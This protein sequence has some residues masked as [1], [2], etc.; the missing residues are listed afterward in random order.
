M[1]TLLCFPNEVLIAITANIDEIQDLAALVLVNRR[2]C[3]IA[4]TALYAAAASN[5][6]TARQALFYSA[7]HGFIE[8]VRLLLAHGVTLHVA[9]ER[10]DD[11]LA[12]LLLESGAIVDPLLA[13]TER[14]AVLGILDGIFVS[15]V[16]PTCQESPLH[17]AIAGGHYSTAKL[18]LDC[19][20]STVVSFGGIKALHVA[21]WHGALDICRLLV[22][23][24]AS[25]VHE[26]TKA[27]LTPFHFAAAAGNVETVGRFLRDK[28]ADIHASF[29]GFV[30]AGNVHREWTCNAFTH[31]LRTRRYSDALMLLDMDPGFAVPRE[32]QLHPVEACFAPRDIVPGDEEQMT[33][34]LKRL[35]LS[36]DRIPPTVSI[37]ILHFV[38]EKQLSRAINVLLEA[39]QYSV[40]SAVY[41]DVSLSKALEHAQSITGVDAAMAL[42][43]YRVSQ[44]G[45]ATPDVSSVFVRGFGCNAGR[46]NHVPDPAD[47]QFTTPGAVEAKL[48]IAKRFHQRL[49]ESPQCVDDQDLRIAL[50]AACQPGG[51]K[52]C[53]WLA[54][55]GALRLL[56]E[57]DFC[58]MLSRTA[59]PPDLGGSDLALAEWVLEQA[60]REGCKCWVLENCD[61][62]RMIIRAEDCTIPRLLVSQGASLNPPDSSKTLPDDWLFPYCTRSRQQNQEYVFTKADNAL[63]TV[64]ANP[65]MTGAAEF[66]RLAS[67]V[68]GEDLGTLVNCAFSTRESSSR[69]LTLATFVCSTELTELN[70]DTSPSEPT[71]LAM[72]KILLGAGA[73]VRAFV[74]CGGK[75]METETWDEAGVAPPE[76]LYRALSRNSVRASESQDDASSNLTHDSQ[77]AVFLWDDDPMRTAIGSRMPTLVQA[78]L[79]AR[80]PPGRNHPGALQYL[81]AACGGMALDSSMTFGR[82]CPRVLE[83]VLSMANLEDANVPVDVRGRTALSVLLDFF[84]TDDYPAPVSEAIRESVLDHECR[85]EPD[86]VAFESNHLSEMVGLL[87]ARGAKWTT[88]AMGTE[89]SALDGLRVLLR[90]SMRFKSMYKRHNLAEF[91]RH[92]ILDIFSTASF[93]PPPDFNPFEMGTIKATDGTYSSIV[94]E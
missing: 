60:D 15:P 33:P 41:L 37:F 24:D 52:V 59:R 78:M 85:C 86:L 28:G 49:A 64:C 44:L 4:Q 19:G 70:G 61:V 81:R 87:L 16:V 69:I 79:E 51:L 32:N 10:G 54:S 34:I 38:S 14:P 36:S 25:L 55:V 26:R 11:K 75:D 63:V 18:L 68:A 23:R 72:L 29:D 57:S 17:C 20:A 2:F 80:P 73:E 22:D 46:I 82:L 13:V 12:K 66:L 50:V 40:P 56:N 76:S 91:R 27:E 88:R 53:Q 8:S 93:D 9:A 92:I 83:V 6:R 43:D 39:P 84:G 31:A 47:L 94:F 65:E 3:S 21:A 42:V 35:L 67:D 45:L 71:R 48:E 30:L 90:D 58:T 77:G 1:T 74:E 62:P 5:R 89:R 7:E